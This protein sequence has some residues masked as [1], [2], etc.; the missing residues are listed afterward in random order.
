[1]RTLR[2]AAGLRVGSA[3]GQF[4]SESLRATSIA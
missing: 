1:M 2:L 4:S 3:A